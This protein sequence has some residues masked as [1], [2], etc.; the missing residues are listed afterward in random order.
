MKKNLKILI[1]ED[2]EVLLSVLSEKLEKIG[3][4]VVS[5][6]DGEAA[7]RVIQASH[8]NLILLDLLLPKKDGFA[9]LEELKSTPTLKTIPVIVLSNLDQDENLKRAFR[10]GVEDYIVKT[11]HTLNEIVEK[12]ELQLARKSK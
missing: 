2:D 3:F 10:L 5:A 9:V 7:M 11:Q 8:P 12:V 1:V 6:M 4:L